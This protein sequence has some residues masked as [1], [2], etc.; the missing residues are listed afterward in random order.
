MFASP[1]I[2][3]F[4]KNSSKLQG[5]DFFHRPIIVFKEQVNAPSHLGMLY[6]A[7]VTKPRSIEF[8]KFVKTQMEHLKLSRT[9]N[10]RISRDITSIIFK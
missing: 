9:D 1:W 2:S 10:E 5:T 8:F 3:W 7:A 4:K 6:K